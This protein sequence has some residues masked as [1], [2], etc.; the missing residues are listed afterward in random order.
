MAKAFSYRLG[1]L[2]V[3]LERE[4]PSVDVH[5]VQWDD[6]HKHCWS[7]AYFTPADSSVPNLLFVGD[8]AL[9]SDVNWLDLRRLIEAGVTY[10][11]GLA[12]EQDSAE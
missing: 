3:R 11:V 6:D 9:K 12:D 7:I 8:R 2:E 4:R 1:N 10:I 5:I